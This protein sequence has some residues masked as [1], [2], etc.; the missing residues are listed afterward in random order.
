M[1]IFLKRTELFVIPLLVIIFLSLI[2]V[3]FALSDTN[4]SRKDDLQFLQTAANNCVWKMNLGDLAKKQAASNAVKQY[5]G[6]MATDHGQYYQELNSLAGRKGVA[7]AADSDR[8]RKNTFVFLSQEYGAAF[9]R[10]YISLMIDDNQR[11]LSLYRKEAEKG[12]DEEIRAFAANII[13]K[14]EG[15]VLAAEKI[16]LDL[17]KPVLK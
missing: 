7:F 16:L 8:V 14:L 11:D 9:D 10:N 13:K 6:I 12:H 1:K 3:T 2:A 5:G 4:S 15:Y 17:P